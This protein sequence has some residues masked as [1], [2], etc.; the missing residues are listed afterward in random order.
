MPGGLPQRDSRVLFS[1]LG[2]PGEALGGMQA[3][4]TGSALFARPYR[5]APQ[6]DR[7]ERR[8]DPNLVDQELRCPL[9]NPHHRTARIEL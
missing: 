3:G 1:W 9:D 6:L 5:F 4:T 2:V 8:A 7:L